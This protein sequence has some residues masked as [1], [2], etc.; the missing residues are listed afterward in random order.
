MSIW[1]GLSAESWRVSGPFHTRD[2]AEAD[3]GLLLGEAF[4]IRGLRGTQIT[5]PT[6][7]KLKR[8]MSRAHKEEASRRWR[9]GKPVPD[10]PLG[11]QC[12]VSLVSRVPQE[13]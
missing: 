2:P 11:L 9:M 4:M 10:L 8:K 5:V 1:L 6:E 3:L 12:Y 7:D 13:A